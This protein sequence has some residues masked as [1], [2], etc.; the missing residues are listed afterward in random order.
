MSTLLI[1]YFVL[2][3]VIFTKV[4]PRSF[5]SLSN[6][7]M[8]CYC[9]SS[10]ICSRWLCL[11]LSG[12]LLNLFL[13]SMVCR[14]ISSLFLSCWRKSII[15]VDFLSDGWLF[16][17]FFTESLSTKFANI[18]LRRL[19]SVRLPPWLPK[20]N[21]LDLL[22]WSEVCLLFL[23][24]LIAF[25]VLGES[26]DITSV[27]EIKLLL[28]DDFS[29]SISSLEFWFRDPSFKVLFKEL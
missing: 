24:R 5:F 29:Y 7:S 27:S 23:A 3:F 2:P 10:L 11:S 21:D 16:G 22:R 9:R 12:S 8:S 1:L 13:I 14:A 15:L 28:L 18:D 4:V 6:F 17:S 19:P 25:L 20:L 26:G